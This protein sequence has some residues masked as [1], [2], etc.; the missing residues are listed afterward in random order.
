MDMIMGVL[1]I[2]LA[3]GFY[4][5]PGLIARARRH[6]RSDAV[7]FLNLIFGWTVI[8]WVALLVWAVIE[9]PAGARP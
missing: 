3:A 6:S 8:G 5:L 9:K 4:F 1:M 2:L 7:L